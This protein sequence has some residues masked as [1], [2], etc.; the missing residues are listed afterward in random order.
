MSL[1]W[2]GGA[3]PEDQS[4]DW[5]EAGWF[6]TGPVLHLEVFSSLWGSR[7]S[8]ALK[9]ALEVEA[10][11]GTNRG[12]GPGREGGVSLWPPTPKLLLVCEERHFLLWEGAYRLRKQYQ[13]AL[14]TWQAF[15]KWC[16]IEMV[17]FLNRE[18]IRDRELCS[19]TF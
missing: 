12:T 16:F 10:L 18:S 7:E 4:E 11:E 14:C 15:S 6:R 17:N 9:A 2:E 8:F 5:Q 3:C 19:T 13:M 1:V